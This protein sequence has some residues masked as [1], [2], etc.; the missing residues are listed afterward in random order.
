M[1]VLEPVDGAYAFRL[2]ENPRT[3]SD[4]DR[5]QL[6]AVLEDGTIEELPHKEPGPLRMVTCIICYLRAITVE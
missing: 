3:T 2:T 6:H 1:T 5:V 4:I